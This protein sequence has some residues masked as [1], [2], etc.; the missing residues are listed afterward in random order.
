[1]TC[2]SIKSGVLLLAYSVQASDKLEDPDQGRICVSKERITRLPFGALSP[3]GC[4]H[5]CL[6]DTVWTSVKWV[7]VSRGCARCSG[8]PGG[9][10][11]NPVLPFGGLSSSE[12]RAPG[13]QV[14]VAE[15]RKAPCPPSCT[16]KATEDMSPSSSLHLS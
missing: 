5:L 2:F 10:A 12:M 7:L 4:M 8:L 11:R 6:R 3:G 16:W 1:M 15:R 9:N 14:E 13:W